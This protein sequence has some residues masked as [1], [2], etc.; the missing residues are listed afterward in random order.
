MCE[1]NKIKGVTDMRLY[2]VVADLC[3]VNEK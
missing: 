3:Y 2:E 1:S